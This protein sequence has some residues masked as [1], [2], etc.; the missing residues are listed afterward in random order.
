MPTMEKIL[1]CGVNHWLSQTSVDRYLLS[2]ELAN[3]EQGLIPVQKTV[4]NGET[5]MGKYNGMT[6]KIRFE[7]DNLLRKYLVLN[8][9]D[10]RQ[11]LQYRDLDE[12][13]DLLPIRTYHQNFPLQWLPIFQTDKWLSYEFPQGKLG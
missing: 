4:K 10:E 11:T 13:L 3:E 1:A 6:N 12:W 9:S 8:W 5:V 2:F 7:D